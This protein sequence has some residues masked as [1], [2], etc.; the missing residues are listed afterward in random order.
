MR[1]SR[2]S[3]FLCLVLLATPALATEISL[4]LGRNDILDRNEDSSSAIGLGIASDPLTHLGPV[5]L[6]VGAG[7]EA[8]DK[9][10]LWGGAGPVLFVPFAEKYR[11]SASVMIGVYEEGK[12][13]DLGSPTEFRS[14]L[15]ISRAIGEDWRLGLAIEH[16]SNASIGETN[17]GI[18]TLFLTVARRF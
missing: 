18:E 9:G 1:S 5:N 15:G 14:R 6:A 7:I 16:K 13:V 3:L 11:I 2:L 8:G 4:S 10:E 12:G 17:P